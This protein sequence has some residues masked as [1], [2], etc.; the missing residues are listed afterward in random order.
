MHFS[1]ASAL[2]PGAEQVCAQPSADRGQDPVGLGAKLPRRPLRRQHRT[3]ESDLG[4]RCFLS[5]R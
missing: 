4:G 2:R 3:E 1:W 5:G